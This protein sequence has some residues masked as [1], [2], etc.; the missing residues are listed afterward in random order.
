MYNIGYDEI[1]CI[2]GEAKNPKRNLPY[3]ILLTLSSVMILYQLAALALV[4]MQPYTLIDG[5]GG[6]SSAFR[7][8][9]CV[10]AAQITAAGEILTLPVVVL[11][12]IMAQPR[13]QYALAVDGLLPYWFAKMD[14]S[15]NL[16]NGTWFS[17]VIMILVASFI[18]FTHLNDMISSGV[19]VAFVFTD[20]SLLLLRRESPLDKEGNDTYLVEKLVVAFNLFSFIFSMKVSH[21]Y[22]LFG[23]ITLDK[24]MTGFLFVGMIGS[25]LCMAIWCPET[26]IFG[27]EKR[28]RPSFSSSGSCEQDEDGFY[29]TP[30]LP[31]LPCLGIFVNWYLI[32]QLE[33]IGVML[34]VFFLVLCGIYYFMYGIKNSLLAEHYSK[35]EV[36]KSTPI[37]TKPNNNDK[38]GSANS[39]EPLL[40]SVPSRDKVKPPPL[41]RTTSF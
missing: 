6:F 19:L 36:Y 35:I 17:G 32:S 8:N 23:N 39:T 24:F 22:V 14:S 30:F 3:A 9:D 4:G 31:F 37:A 10:W 27:C 15:G 16:V 28:R 21:P 20:T 18:P 29:K 33:F 13:L 7:Y 41:K 25:C 11:I 40:F 12:T 5:V 38:N 34:L 1:C 26:K 2:A